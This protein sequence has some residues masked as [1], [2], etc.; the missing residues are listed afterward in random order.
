MKKNRGFTITSPDYELSP[1]TGMGRQHWIDAGVYLLKGM[2]DS[3]GSIEDAPIV[4]RTETEVTYPHLTASEGQQ[5]A[6][7]RA[8]IF[9]GLTRTFFIGSVLIHNDPE[10]RIGDISLRDY[11]SLHILNALTKKDGPEYVGSYDELVEM[12]GSDD[13]TRCFQQTVETCALVIGLWACKDEIW[14]RY[15]K[16]ER[17]SI[18]AFLSGYANAATVP[19]NWRLF[20]ML[21]MAFLHMEGYE[22]DEHV[23]REHAQAILHYYAGDGWYRDGHSFDYYSC[24]AFNV[25]A[26]IWN[27]WYGYENEPYIASKFEEAT[28]ALMETYPDFFDRDGHTMMWGRSCIYR[29]A[30][31]S[32]FDADF[33]LK[34]SKVDP[35]RARRICS[36]SLLQFL[37]RDDLLKNGVPSL[38]FYDQFMPLVQGYSCAESVYW[39]GKAFLCLHLP[40][41]HPFWTAVE[42]NGDWKKDSK[43]VKETI[44]NGPAL[45]FTNHNANGGNIL[46]TGKI[47][48]APEDDH[49][50]WNYSKISYHSQ[51][52]WEA[53][54]TGREDLESQQYVLFDKNDGTYKKCNVT[55]WNGERDNV[56]Y[57]RQFFGYNLAD[58]CH[59]INAMNLADIPVAYGLIRVDKARLFRPNLKLT[60]GTY[61]FPDDGKTEI[62]RKDFKY[63]V[64]GPHSIRK[65]C[66]AH[67]IIMKG[68]DSQG[69]M[70]QLAFTLYTGWQNI[71]IA[72]STGTNPDSKN[73]LI[74]YGSFDKEH[75]YDSSESYV[76]ISQTITREDFEDFTDEELFPITRI[77]FS[78]PDCTGCYG[79]I[80]LKLHDGVSKLNE[81]TVNYEG[82]EGCLS[83]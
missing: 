42:N 49:G 66:K 47:L 8:E 71:D 57:R 19:Q 56:L 44:L 6:E 80:V 29:F 11:Y 51:Y 78:D 4:P 24:W 75:L 13:P 63:E 55:F 20:N 43:D 33:L 76:F 50:M 1:Y 26:P 3:L 65:R 34:K 16:E 40:K 54:P 17:D 81:Y 14:D 59:W 7:R 77:K 30:A 35:G 5:D 82:M 61:G 45:C 69:E 68:H 22:I 48:K 10:I 67:A 62:I 60:L 70:K 83:L 2:F 39:L 38:G 52:P 58:E 28:N 21:D 36:G 25:Y 53:A 37:G 46:R 9:E 72:K 32:P 27:V 15:S 18:A 23:M 64:T 12:T 41:D 73:S 31:V 74:A 79:N